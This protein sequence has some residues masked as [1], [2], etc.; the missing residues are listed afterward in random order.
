MPTAEPTASPTPVPT[1]TPAPVDPT[2]P[3]VLSAKFATPPVAN[4]V[5]NLVIEVLDPDSPVLGVIIDLGP[6]GFVGHLACT[7]L[8]PS[9]G[10]KPQTFTI[11][12]LFT[13]PGLQTY[14]V[15]IRSGGRSSSPPW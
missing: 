9:R 2:L 8:T 6:A 7:T 3:G 14:V 10:G 13:A 4:K 1:A 15:Q 11:P 5:T 12:V